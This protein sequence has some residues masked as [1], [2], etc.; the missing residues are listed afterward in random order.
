MMTAVELH[1]GMQKIFSA[2]GYTYM[3]EV[4]NATGFD[5]T[6]SADALALGMYQSRG[7][8]LWGMEMKVSR[9]DW[10]KELG[11]ADKAESW[12]RFCDRWALVVS[13]QAMVEPGELPSTWGLYAPVKGK[14]KCLTPCPRLKPQPLTRI[15]L[16]AL[17]Y[18]SS[19]VDEAVIRRR[20]DAEVQQAKQAMYDRN[21]YDADAYRRLSARVKAF[22]QHSGINLEYKDEERMKEIGTVVNMILAGTAGI[23]RRLDTVE[24]A[25]QA[26]KEMVP[27]MERQL[28][29]LKAAQAMEEEVAHE[30]EA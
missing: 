17:L 20:I 18:A 29:L 21:Q 19:K 15:A 23:Q 9:S 27:A 10:V 22:E 7:L 28:E 25:V 30:L 24:Y 6:R 13:D 8:E 26:V 1:L 4:R 2:P 5:A 3:R 16:T 12:L 14:L 11:Q